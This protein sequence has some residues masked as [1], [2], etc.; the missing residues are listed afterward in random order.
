MVFLGCGEGFGLVGGLMGFVA[1][2]KSKGSGGINLRIMR[3]RPSILRLS[4]LL[5]KCS[6][7]TIS[8]LTRKM[9]CSWSMV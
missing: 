5:R 1:L 2:P 7:F 3:R 9:I 6:H 8:N 4:P